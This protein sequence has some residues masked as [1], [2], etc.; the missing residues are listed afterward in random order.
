MTTTSQSIIID[1]G[2]REST[3]KFLDFAIS[4]STKLL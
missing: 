3:T 2:T 1:G 4:S